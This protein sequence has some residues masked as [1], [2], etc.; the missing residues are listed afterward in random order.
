VSSARI[1]YSQPGC[2]PCATHIRTSG[3]R[4]CSR[5]DT[6]P[7][8]TTCHL[9]SF[10]LQPQT[11]H[12]GP[13]KQLYQ[14]TFFQTLLPPPTTHSPYPFGISGCLKT[15]PLKPKGPVGTRGE[16]AP[17]DRRRH[18]N[19]KKHDTIRLRITINVSPSSHYEQGHWLWGAILPFPAHTS[20]KRTLLNLSDELSNQDRLPQ[21]CGT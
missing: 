18:S 6:G 16:P 9:T 1:L 21:L 2:S 7:L 12:I 19:T 10:Y 17:G 8:R 3:C 20:M 13:N 5:E 15:A 14:E 4:L 11:S